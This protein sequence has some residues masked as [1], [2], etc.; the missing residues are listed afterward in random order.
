[1]C[2]EIYTD[3]HLH[4]QFLSLLS[5]SKHP[6]ANTALCYVSKNKSEI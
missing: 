1:M 3:A 5:W 6:G 2:Y 4:T